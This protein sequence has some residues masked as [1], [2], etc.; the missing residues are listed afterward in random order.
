MRFLLS[1]AMI[2]VSTSSVIAADTQVAYP[3]GFR[4]WHHVKSM[5]IEKGHPL[6]DA[7]GGMHH[8]Y[9]N[10]KA[11]QGYRTGRFPDG[12]VIV[13]DLVEATR[14]ENALTEGTRK[15]VGVMHK[16]ARKFTGTGGWGF[17]GF[18]A[19]EKGNR[20]VGVKAAEAC[21]GCHAPQKDHD[22]V[23]SRLRE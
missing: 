12:A 4:G 6:F 10:K 5:V 20:V 19:G 2:A 3:D 14:A 7:F 11:V 23:F 22:Y 17:E 21:F 8:I 13:F 9:A 15:V 18:G 1:V 16:D